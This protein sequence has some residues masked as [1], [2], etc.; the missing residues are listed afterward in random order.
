[1]ILTPCMLSYDPNLILRSYTTI[2]MTQTVP[3]VALSGSEDGGSMSIRNVSTF[4]RLT[5]QKPK[6]RSEFEKQQPPS[7]PDSF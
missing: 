3:N 2:S 6:G 4:N 5:L 1:V 7:E